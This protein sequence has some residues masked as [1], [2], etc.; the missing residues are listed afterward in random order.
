MRVE[1][2]VGSSQ[3]VY[4]PGTVQVVL[5]ADLESVRDGL[6]DLFCSD[7]LASLTEESRGVVEIVL[8]EVLNNVVEHGYATYSGK[9]VVWVTRREN[10]LFI[11]MVDQGLP[12]P[13]AALPGGKLAEPH[14][15]AELPE[16]GFG[17][18]LIRTMSDELNYRRDGD[19]NI[20]SFCVNVDYIN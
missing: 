1:Q 6:R 2:N 7:H 9:I 16:G 4:S 17:W 18:F 5:A 14:D 3:S 13:G 8:A 20:L 15:S 10:Y 19:Q 12:M 11:R